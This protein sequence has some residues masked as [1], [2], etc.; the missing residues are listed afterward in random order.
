MS[1]SLIKF[2]YTDKYSYLT[3][4]SNINNFFFIILLKFHQLFFFEDYKIRRKKKVGR[5]TK[6]FFKGLELCKI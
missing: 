5:C 6:D 2:K 3:S 4:C 1:C